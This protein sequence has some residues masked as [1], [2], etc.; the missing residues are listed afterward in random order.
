VRLVRERE[1]WRSKVNRRSVRVKKRGREEG[2]SFLEQ[3]V[4][5]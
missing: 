2:V 4:G 1:W 5:L 3:N